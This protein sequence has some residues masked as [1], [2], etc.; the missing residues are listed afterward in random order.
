MRR[1]RPC[2]GLL[3]TIV[4]TTA[5][6]AP[7]SVQTSGLR[8]T[9]DLGTLTNLSDAQG[10]TCVRRKTALPGVVIHCVGG[11]RVAQ[12][13]SGLT[14][15]DGQGRAARHYESFAN[16]PGASERVPSSATPRLAT[17]V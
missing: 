15:P 2:M 11:D 14:T 3:L 5:N 4:A 13:A 6:A 9:F 1:L 16:L 10:H 17:W 8:S 7:L 12:A